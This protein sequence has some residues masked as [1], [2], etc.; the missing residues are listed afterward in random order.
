MK[1]WH[2]LYSICMYIITLSQKP[3]KT[4]LT[5]KGK[6]KIKEKHNPEGQKR[7][8]EA[9]RLT[10]TRGQT[11]GDSYLALQAPVIA[12]SANWRLQPC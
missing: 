10:Q 1:F 11:I 2:I 8:Q 6:E 9:I 12:V 5:N 4:K 3:T 7:V